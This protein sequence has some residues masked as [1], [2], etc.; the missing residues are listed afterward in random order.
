MEGKSFKSLLMWQKAHI[1]VLLVYDITKG[2]PKEEMF[3]LI[4]QFRRASVSISANI[5]EGYKRKT[6][7]EKLRFFNIAQASLEECRY[8]I[9]L[10]RDLN[11]INIQYE[12]KLN[13]AI[14]E[15]SKT[16]NAYCSKIL[17]SQKS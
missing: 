5:V 16:L 10:S 4:S 14:E 15:A 11:Y 3:G 13:A 1:F 17:E 6:K 8:Y 9:L 2:F 7:I 12:N